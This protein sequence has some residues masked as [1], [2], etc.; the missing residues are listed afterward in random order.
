MTDPLW[1]KLFALSLLDEVRDFH[2][3]LLARIEDPLARLYMEQLIRAHE[4]TARS[5]QRIG[6]SRSL[7]EEAIQAIAESRA[8]SSDSFV[9]L[10]HSRIQIQ[11][12]G[13]RFRS[14]ADSAEIARIRY[15]N[16]RQLPYLDATP[17][18]RHG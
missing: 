1:D 7:R 13:R 2:A 9:L 5:Y 8:L 18:K 12:N 15:L 11:R 17:K 6:D 16:E 10:R 4:Q 3:P 14:P